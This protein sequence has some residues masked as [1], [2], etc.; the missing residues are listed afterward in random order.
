MEALRASVLRVFCCWAAA[1]VLMAGV[2]ARAQSASL[3]AQ[4]AQA[5]LEK[6]SNLR[7][8]SKRLSWLLMDART[9]QLLASQWFD[10]NKPIPVGS[11]TK[12]FVALAYSRT[13]TGFPRYICAGMS[14]RCWLPQGHGS[15]SLEQAVTLSCN[16]Y[17]LQLAKET[18]PAAIQEVA[19]EYGLPNAPAPA[20]PAEW[21]GLDSGW[22]IA[23]LDLGRAYLRMASRP[24]RPLYEME[25]AKLRLPA[26]PVHSLARM[27]LPRLVPLL[28]STIAWPAAT[29][30]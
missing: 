21:I 10:A 15:L 3:F 11:L 4:S 7:S 8:G 2:S 26:P 18:S 12:P 30:W 19:L 24:K 25:C 22:R 1:L 6:A 9:G 28:A 23:P 5:A 14:T 17:F 13:H 20:N 27:R 16:S 29:A